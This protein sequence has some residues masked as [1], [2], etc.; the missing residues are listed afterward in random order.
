MKNAARIGRRL[1]AIQRDFGLETKT[2]VFLF[3]LGYTA[4]LVE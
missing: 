1:T 2:F 3:E 4:A